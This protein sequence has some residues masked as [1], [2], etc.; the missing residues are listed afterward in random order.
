MKRLI[1]PSLKITGL[2]LLIALLLLS[3]CSA[4][5]KEDDPALLEEEEIEEEIPE[6]EPFVKEFEGSFIVAVDNHINAYPQSGLEK[7]DLV[8]EL[9]AEGGVTR[10]LAFYDSYHAE[11][12]G[13]VRSA[14]YYFAE[15]VKGYPS[16]FAHAG[17]NAD[18]L[19]LIPHLKIMDLDEIYNSGAAFVRTKDRRPPHNLYTSTEMMLKHS[20]SKGFAIKDLEGLPLG[21][22]P[23]IQ[24]EELKNGFI[25]DLPYTNTKYYYHSVTY[26]YEKEDE[27]Y[28]RYVNGK[29]FESADGVWLAPD[30]LI[31]MEIPSRTVVKEEVQSEMNVL[32]Q[33]KALFLRDGIV[34]EGSWKKEKTSQP[35]SFYHEGQAMNFKEGQTW[36]QIISDMKTIKIKGDDNANAKASDQSSP[37]AAS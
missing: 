28:Y 16:A 21:E 17:G 37:K 36:I 2:F 13:P 25:I 5:N 12:I 26:V 3:G 31:I 24:P 10:F 32:G 30:N 8:I 23:Q 6:K 11:K 20:K 27:K 14:R 22:T 34:Y 1:C 29:K 33:G 7:A 35:F 9:M 15:I 4:K 19:A 18:A